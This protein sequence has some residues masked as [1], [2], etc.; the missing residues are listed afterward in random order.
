M[1][2]IVIAA[3][4]FSA[5]V[6]AQ[7]VAPRRSVIIGC[8]GRQNATS[9]FV[10]TDTRA[11]PPLLYRLDGDAKQLAL[12]VGHTLEIAGTLTPP[13]RANTP[14]VLKISSLTWLSKTCAMAR[15]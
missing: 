10:L 4:L 9:P 3:V 8:V 1:T 2:R 12:H 7:T 13:T 6:Q 11:D 14:P 15:R 5:A